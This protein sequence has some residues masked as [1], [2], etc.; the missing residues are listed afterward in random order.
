[1]KHDFL[2]KKIVSVIAVEGDHASNIGLFLFAL[3]GNKDPSHY[4]SKCGFRL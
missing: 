4:L 2:K 3:E 1:M